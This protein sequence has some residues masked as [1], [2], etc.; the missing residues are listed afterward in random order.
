MNEPNRLSAEFES[1]AHRCG[2][3]SEEAITNV[4][5]LYLQGAKAA[6]IPLADIATVSGYGPEFQQCFKML[7]REMDQF[8]TRFIEEWPNEREKAQMRKSMLRELA[9]RSVFRVEHQGK[10]DRW[11]VI[12]TARRPKL[13]PGQAPQVINDSKCFDSEDEAI[14][15]LIKEIENQTQETP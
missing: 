3:G 14:E 12:A 4:K 1:L 6:L 10:P 13:K 7:C 8:H 2:I 11:C 5:R 9:R 15:W